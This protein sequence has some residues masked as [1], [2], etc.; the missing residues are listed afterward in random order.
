MTY[1]FT[2]DDE[3]DVEAPPDDVWQAIT[4]GA[5]MDSW[6]MGRSEIEPRLG[7]TVRTDFDG[8][9]IESTVTAWEPPMRLG[10]RG[11]EDPDGAYM[12]FEWRI[13]ARV[14]GGSTVH[15]THRGRLAGGDAEAEYAALTKG[16]PMYLRKLARYLEYFNGQIATR[17]IIVQGPVVPDSQQFRLRLTSALGLR[18]SVTEWDAVHTTLDGLGTIEGVVDYVTP[19][20]VG[21]R[22][23]TGLYRFIYGL[24]GMVVVEHHDFAPGA[25][26]NAT[27]AAWQVWLAKA[28]ESVLQNP[29]Y[30]RS[31]LQAS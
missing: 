28:F 8:F 4:L 30:S 25:N 1:P 7:G 2:I 20:F 18:T 23:S 21:L 27:T 24:G 3:I 19:E 29:P 14:G 6:F 12:E 22:T 10:H 26:G 15:F 13:D 17:N 11:R 5:R 9:V 31:S 16:D